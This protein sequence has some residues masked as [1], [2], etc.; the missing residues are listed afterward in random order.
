MHEYLDV[1]VSMYEHTYVSLRTVLVCTIMYEYVF[2]TELWSWLIW[3][4]IDFRMTFSNAP[5]S[6]TWTSSPPRM[7]PWL[8]QRDKSKT[9]RTKSELISLLIVGWYYRYLILVIILLNII[10]S[11]NICKVN[12]SD[13]KHF[14]VTELNKP[15]QSSFDIKYF[16][17]VQVRAWR[18]GVSE[19]EPYYSKHTE[20][21]RGRWERHWVFCAAELPTAA[22]VLSVQL[23]RP[24][25]S[26]V[27]HRLLLALPSQRLR[28]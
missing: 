21:W 23:D 5:Y 13:A 19:C 15:V 12:D 16:I 20:Y 11:L 4:C 22:H 2:S 24:R 1:L 26:H 17:V 14:E 25:R 8:N 18:M 10:D 3:L 6:S 27:N 9:W 28:R 7:W